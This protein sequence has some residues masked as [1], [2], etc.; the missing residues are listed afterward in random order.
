MRSTINIIII[1]LLLT[2]SGACK[3]FLVINPET[4]ISQGSFYKS[5][6]DF[7]QAV[8][9]AYAQL[10]FMYN[11]AWQLT[12]LRSDNTYFIYDRGNRGSKPA[13]DFATFTV[14]TNNNSLNNSWRSNYLIIARANQVLATIDN[15]D[16]DPVV[17]ANLKGQALFLRALSYF[18]LVKQFGRIPLFTS[19]ATNYD[20]TFHPQLSAEQIYI[21]I[22]ADAGE[23]AS[24]MLPKSSSTLVGRATSGAA[25]TLLADVYLT[26][27]RW[28]DAED[29][30]EFVLNMGYELL[31]NYAD[32]FNPANKGN[33][34][35]IFE[36][37]YI[38]GHPNGLYS[39]FPYAF[40]PKLEDP[41][42]ITGVSPG[43]SNVRV[44]SFNIPTPDLIESYEDAT[45]DS[46]FAA[47]I[48]F[49][50]GPSPMSGIPTYENIP[51]I[52]KYQHAHSVS[53]QTPQNWIVYRFAEVLLMYAEVLNEQD[54]PAEARP[55]L[56][57]VRDRAGLPDITSND[58]IVLQAAIRHERRIELAFENKRWHDL[59]RT[60]EAVTVM[61]A[62]GDRVIAN[63]EKY[64]Y[65]P[66]DTPPPNAFNVTTNSSI[67]P[68]PV[69]E[70]VINP[71]L[72]QNEG[73]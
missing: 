19:P 28:A 26:L 47:S 70:M 40:L 49:Y 55:F 58:K 46:R 57:Q 18:N 31:T 39:T 52:K 45:T 53:G 5:Q 20:E 48:G 64:Y 16:F 1:C 15:A 63:P 21:Q 37:N 22:I 30:L 24:L 35:N 42:V 8:T 38:Q 10:Q 23:S 54:R 7:E 71:S 41:S 12:E 44:G 4:N 56:N 11:E 72:T 67:Y 3:K 6:S 61:N 36:I 43:V 29:A 14:E 25:Y 59:V 50:T 69:T 66:G 62:F 51:Y 17:K 9:G 34:E 2:T 68:I 65:A 27:G 33:A 32:V 73:Y 13:E 60:G